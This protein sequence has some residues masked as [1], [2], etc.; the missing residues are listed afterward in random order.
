[1]DVVAG[2][3]LLERVEEVLSDLPPAYAMAFH[4]RLREGF[5]YRE[6]SSICEEPEGTLRSRVHHG[7]KRVREA[8]QRDGIEAP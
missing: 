5:S 8:L 4:L 2:R 1:V 3:E 7:L 6:M